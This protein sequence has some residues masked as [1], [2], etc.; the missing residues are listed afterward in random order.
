[1]TNK[2]KNNNIFKNMLNKQRTN[3]QYDKKLQSVSKGTEPE[4]NILF[5]ESCS[6]PNGYIFDYNILNHIN[7]CFLS[8]L[9]IFLIKL[10]IFINGLIK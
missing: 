3:I 9:K 1:M 7:H 5:T 6:N 4:L 8:V 10:D 2:Y